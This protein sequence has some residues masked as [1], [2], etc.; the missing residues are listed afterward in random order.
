AFSG[1]TAALTN[2]LARHTV[3]TVG[4]TAIDTIADAAQG[5]KVTPASLATSLVF[6]AA[7]EGITSKI[8]KGQSAKPTQ[9][10]A[11]PAPKQQSKPDFYVA[12]DGTTYFSG[13][14]T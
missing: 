10:L 4:E 1:S 5:G 6:N 9:Q 7:T 8:A 3:D 13:D 14:S 12:P 2:P 11:L